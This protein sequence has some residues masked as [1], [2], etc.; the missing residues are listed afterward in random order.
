MRFAATSLFA[1]SLVG[2]VLA[3]APTPTDIPAGPGYEISAP[4]LDA[5]YWRQIAPA[6]QS[7]GPDIIVDDFKTVTYEKLPLAGETSPRYLN[8]LGGDYGEPEP[9]ANCSDI[10]FNFTVNADKQVM[11]IRPLTASNPSC[12]NFWFFKLDPGACFD[13]SGIAALSFDLVAPAGASFQIG[14]TQKSP[15]CDY[16]IGGESGK[17]DSVY[18]PISA[19]ITNDGTKHTAVIPFQDFRGGFDFSHLKDMTFLQ[20][21]PIGAVFEMSNIRLIRECNG[22]GPYGPTPFVRSAL[23]GTTPTISSTAGS[24]AT[25]VPSGSPTA[26]ST[27]GSDSAA[28]ASNS[29]SLTPPAGGAKSG[30]AS[31]VPGVLALF[32]GVLA[33]L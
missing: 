2:T 12:A 22:N 21:A 23:N 16:R 9:N 4:Y 11:E 32:A 14:M 31:V 8:L 28:G 24:V 13:L 7:C 27:N 6:N 15:S 26:P 20:F 10:G 19:Y 5:P 3:Q 33:L 29:S 18:R 30:A 25:S 1:S 17:G